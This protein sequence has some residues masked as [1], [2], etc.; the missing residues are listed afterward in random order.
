[1]SGP[2][3]LLTAAAA[4]RVLSRDECEAIAKKLLSFAT[5][6]ET[7]VSIG[8]GTRGNTRFAVNQISTSGDAFDANVSVRSSF[9]R[10]SAAAVT[11]AFD[12]A[13]LKAVVERAE[14]LARLAP[15]TVSR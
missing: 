9:G 8:S 11:N 12:D 7:S 5:A 6:D 13:S 1:M 3:S 10:R 4:P 2:K 15:A 14:A